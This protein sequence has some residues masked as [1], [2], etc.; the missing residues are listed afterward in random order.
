MIKQSTRATEGTLKTGWSGMAAED[1]IHTD[2]KDAKRTPCVG[3]SIASASA[4]A[5]WWEC[6]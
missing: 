6:A 1:V 2:D 4:K 5:L 3:E